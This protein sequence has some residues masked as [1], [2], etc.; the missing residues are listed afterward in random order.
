MADRILLV[1]GDTLPSLVVSLY[2]DDYSYPMDL[3]GCTV[4]MRFREAGSDTVKAILIGQ[5]MPGVDFGGTGNPSLA[6]PY[7]QA[8]GRG[9]RVQFNWGVDDLDAEGAYEG[10]VEVTSASNLIQT[11]YDVMKFKVRSQF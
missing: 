3:R 11:V 9:G 7:D 2:R 5:L 10:E 1:Q 6:P 4:R 8:D